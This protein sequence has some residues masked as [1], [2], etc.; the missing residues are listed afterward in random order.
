[1]WHPG[2][3]HCHIVSISTIVSGNLL[4]RKVHRDHEHAVED[5]S[6][7]IVADVSGTPRSPAHRLY[8]YKALRPP[9]PL[10]RCGQGPGVDRCTELTGARSRRGKG[11]EWTADAEPI[12]PI[13]P[14]ARVCLYVV[15]GEASG[16]WQVVSG[17]GER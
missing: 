12:E 1:M 8:G 6:G 14:I 11:D 7:R 15:G 10:R 16:R 2:G 3:L 13:E 5:V 9:G 17:W 4:A